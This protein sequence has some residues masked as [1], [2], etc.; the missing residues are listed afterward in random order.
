MTHP[1]FTEGAAEVV[2]ELFRCSSCRRYLEREQFNRC[3]SKPGGVDN[4]C[5]PCR[6]DYRAHYYVANGEALK[7][8]AVRQRQDRADL[9][10]TFDFVSK[11][12][13]ATPCRQCGRTD[14]R[15]YLKL[16]QGPRSFSLW[17]AQ[18]NGVTA[19]AVREELKKYDVV[20]GICSG[21]K[22]PYAGAY[23]KKPEA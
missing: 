11:H 18:R 8:K 15:R 23:A 2:H 6:R 17:S 7:A 16:R 9:P 12:V 5:R 21:P 10:G 3:S 22:C 14:R 4:Y 1:H 13:K 20:C 19:G